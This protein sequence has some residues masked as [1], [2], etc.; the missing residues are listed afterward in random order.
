MENSV[1]T[2][3][4][5]PLIKG[6]IMILL[7]VLIFASPGSALVAW[8]LYIGIGFIAAGVLLIFQ[9][10]SARGVEGWG[11]RVF[12]GILD[13]FIGF[14]LMSN[15]L[16]TAA[17]L[18]FVFGFWGAFYGI[19]LFIDSFSTGKGKG[20]KMIAGILIFLLATLIMFNPVMAG[21]TVAVWVGIIL[22]VAGVYNVIFAFSIK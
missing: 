3:W 6:I 11:W 18:P 5:L 19:A 22:V 21:M 12:E 1:T 16:V 13:L 2:N 4:Y 8:A 7:A 14:M 20:T 9:G 15:P 10:F 17:V